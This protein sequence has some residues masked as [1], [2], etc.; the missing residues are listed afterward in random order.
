MID[1]CFSRTDGFTLIE[2]L[3]ATTILTIGVVSVAY[4]TLASRNSSQSALRITTAAVLAQDEME[5]LRAA[6]WPAAASAQCC[7]YFDAD[8]QSLAA[9]GSPPPGTAYIRRSSIDPLPS[10][11]GGACLVQVWV[12]P[13]RGAGAAHLVG[14]RSRRVG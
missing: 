1:R 12:A 13:A 4:L 11:P 8:A 2:A 6:P 7:E 3:V 9:G 10:N 5:R 14:V